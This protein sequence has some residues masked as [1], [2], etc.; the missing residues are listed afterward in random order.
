MPSNGNGGRASGQHGSE[1]KTDIITLTRFLTEE[2][3]RLGPHAT[4][5][6]TW[7]TLWIVHRD[8]GTER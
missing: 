6:F 1:V 8:V 2:Q 5:D 7:V 4:G 3:H